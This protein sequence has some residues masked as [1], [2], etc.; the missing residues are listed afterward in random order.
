[1]TTSHA[2][3][4]DHVGILNFADGHMRAGQAKWNRL[5]QDTSPRS[6]KRKT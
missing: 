3:V 1:M 2:M 4:H 6:G 5:T